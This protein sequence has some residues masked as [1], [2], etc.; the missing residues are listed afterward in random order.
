MNID[1]NSL[2]GKF[3]TLE[4]LEGAGKTTC[5]R[6]IESY[7]KKQSVALLLTREPGGTPFAEEIRELLLAPR[8]EKVNDDVELLLMF[9]ARA[10]HLNQKI[11]PALQSGQWVLSDRFTDATYAYQGA[12]R[13]I[14][15]GKIAQLEQLVQKSLQPDLTL[16]LDVPI[17]VGLQRANQRGELDRFEREEVDFFQRVREAYLQRAKLYS[18]RFV[19][20]DTNRELEEVYQSISTALDLFLANSK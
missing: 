16:F 19:I 5:I 3:I 11:L 12:G 4:G 13:G 9:A 1:S 18:S 10:Q 6:Y 14:D 20:I 2:T 7:F 8:D 15:A 17:E